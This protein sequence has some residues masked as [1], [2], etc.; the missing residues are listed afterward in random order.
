M[1]TPPSASNLRDFAK[2]RFY[3]KS[4]IVRVK[5]LR[6]VMRFNEL[7]NIERNL[8]VSLLLLNPENRSDNDARVRALKRIWIMDWELACSVL[9]CASDSSDLESF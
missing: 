9:T 4:C 5:G 2:S 1:T 6:K 7:F 3:Q 8:L